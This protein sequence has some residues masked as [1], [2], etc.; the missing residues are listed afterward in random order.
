MLC[1]VGLFIPLR[2][3]SPRLRDASSAFVAAVLLA[4]GLARLSGFIGGSGLA[5]DPLAGMPVPVAAGAIALGGALLLVRRGVAL[6]G[7]P[8]AGWRQIPFTV[9]IALAAF[10]CVLWRSLAMERSRGALPMEHRDVLALGADVRR[11]VDLH[12]AVLKRLAHHPVTNTADWARSAHGQIAALPAFAAVAWVA[13]TLETRVVVS[14]D[15]GRREAIHLPALAAARD[16]SAE[17][18]GLVAV[19]GA[20][21]SGAALLHVHLRADVEDT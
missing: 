2:S 6:L 17:V 10:S 14:P 8:I 15:P 4:G 16:R 19:L 21:R 3:G 7:A 13:P 18:V 1:G 11:A 12:A 20:G 5:W 9:T